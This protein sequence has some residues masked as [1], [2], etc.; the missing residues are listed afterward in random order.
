[1]LESERVSW[2][3]S[4]CGTPELLVGYNVGKL[5]IPWE[6][7]WPGVAEAYW[8]VPLLEKSKLRDSESW[9][10]GHPQHGYEN[11]QKIMKA[12]ILKRIIM[13]QN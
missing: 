10:I 9:A 5:Q 7:P 1:M 6:R 2:K 12:V 3:L 8:K 11:H 4:V 13:N